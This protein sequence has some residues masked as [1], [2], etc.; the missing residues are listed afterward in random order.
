MSDIRKPH[1]DSNK[2]KPNIGDKIVYADYSGTLYGGTIIGFTENGSIRM[3][4]VAGGNRYT[5]LPTE[6]VF[7]NNNYL[8]ITKA[9]L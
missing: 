5:T 6:F 9:K 7:S 1:N 3:K 8:N 4:A 2:R